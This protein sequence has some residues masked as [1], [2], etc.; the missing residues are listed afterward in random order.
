MLAVQ[1][2]LF[3]PDQLKSQAYIDTPLEIGLGQ[4]I[5]APHMVAIM[6]EALDIHPGQTILEIGAGS[7]YHAAVAA[8]IIEP[9]GHLHTIERFEQLAHQAI[10]NLKTAKISNV[11]VHIGDGSLGLEQYAPYDRIYITCASPKIPP[12]L[13]N[14]LDD[15]GKLLI[16]VGRMVCKLE[17]I[18]K[19]ESTL[20]THDLGGCVFVPLVGVHGY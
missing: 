6:C 1:R 10:K 13:L 14:Q 16:P 9:Q 20:T 3:L 11:T 4:T 5:S 8:H 19:K 17:L 12:P 15:P 18:E 7:G 2:E